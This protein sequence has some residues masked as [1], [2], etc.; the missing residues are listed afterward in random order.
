MKRKVFLLAVTSL[1]FACCIAQDNPTLNGQIWRGNIARTGEFKS[2]GPLKQIRLKWKFL[3][4]GAIKSSPVIFNE[5]VYVGSDDGNIYAINLLDGKEKWKFSTGAPVQSSAAIFAGK[6]FFINSRGVHAID[7]RTGDKIWIKSG[8]FW[9]DSPLV[10]PGPIKDKSGKNLEG[11][12]FFSEPWKNLV[13]LNTAD[14]S[15]VWRC[16][17]GHGPG[18]RGNSAL[19]HRGMLIF[20]RGS[21]ATVVVDVLTERKKYE[22]D[23]AIDNGVFTPAARNGICYSYIKGIVAFDIIEN[24]QITAKNSS[25][26]K[27]KWRFDPGKENG[28][29]YQHPGISSI[30]VDEKNVYFGHSDTYVYALNKENGEVVWKT[31]TG[32]VNR[33]SPAIGSGDLLFIGSYNGNVYGI[34]K[35]DGTIVW[36]FKTGGAVHSS[37]AIEKSILVVGSDDGC[38]YAIE[39]EQ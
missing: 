15:E 32:G 3:T 5:T 26:Y 17:D 2:T 27:I 35:N 19:L 31:S 36:Q 13:G 9:D 16:R 7:I 25:D 38:L 34:S 21:Q 1:I 37:P 23:G 6:V 30:S 11:V 10:I 33:S 8:G 12:L 29:D 20:F 39:E 4:G 24:S 14:G 22:I 28:W 18:S